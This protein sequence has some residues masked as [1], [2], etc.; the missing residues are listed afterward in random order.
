MRV[1]R[2]A[3]DLVQ[4]LARPDADHFGGEVR[5]H[6]FGQV[7]NTY[8]RDHRHKNLTTRHPLEAFNDE[9]DTLLKGYPKTGHPR[10]G[11]RQVIGTL[12]DQPVVKWH[13]RTP[14]ADNIAIA[15]D[16]E[17]CAMAASH[18]VR[19]AKQL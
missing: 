14:R 3:H 17:S 2:R 18:V 16:G 10:I 12:G 15:Y 4:L 8:R 7:R 11:D 19:G 9:V 13:D 6:R 5:G 1:I